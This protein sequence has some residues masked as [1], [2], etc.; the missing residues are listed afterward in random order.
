MPEEAAVVPM[1]QALG[2]HAIATCSHSARQP[3]E[4]YP[5]RFPGVPERCSA[6]QTLADALALE[7]GDP[8]SGEPSP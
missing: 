4:A 7:D 6:C 3:D 5:W 1:L 8:P 2:R